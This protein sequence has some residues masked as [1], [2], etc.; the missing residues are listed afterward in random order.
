MSILLKGITLIDPTSSFN[1]QIINIVI[2][3]G[4]LSY[5]GTETKECDQVIDGNGLC[6]SAGWIDMRCWIGDPGLEHK[7]DIYS[8]AVAA[9]KG[10]FTQILCLP[11]V[12]PVIQSKN[13]INY[14]QHK[15]AQLPVSFLA[16]GS[17][18]ADGLGKD[19]TEMI[20]LHQA[21]A[22]A[23]TDGDTGIQGADLLIKA[24]QYAR[25]FDGLIMQRSQDERLAQHGLMHEGIQSASLG[26]KGIPALAEDVMID[27]DL[28]L[29]EYAGG[30]I[31]FSLLS[32]YKSVEKIRKAKAKGLAVSCDI[33]SY[34]IAFTD[35]DIQPFD[36]NYKV[37]PP[38][39]SK[40][41]R[42]ALV[43]GLADGTI[44]ILVSGH[45]PQD[46]ESKKLE[47]DLA[48]FGITNLET[49][50]A[51]ANTYL[52]KSISLENII[53]KFT[54]APRKVLKLPNPVLQEGEVANLTIFN[55]S[56]TWVPQMHLRAS[57]SDNSPFY[58]QTLTG[59]VFGIVNK[60]QFITNPEY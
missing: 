38:F 54:T 29:L 12:D 57:K 7:E 44:D 51:V 25:Y 11:D 59:Q 6:V 22:L 48:E 17:V 30:K 23:F 1:K 53:S 19:L 35:E 2:T 42:D 50:F 4:I 10:G 58:G 46:T 37:N 14:L 41:D 34:Q 5:L 15:S 18:S 52:G 8:A 49:A 13:A 31:H 47:F 32:T 55:P 33:A 43:Q 60:N 28:Q 40:K 9:A 26:L 39:R 16:A 36:T 27:R 45:K 24:L 20:D 21:G 3:D 56:K